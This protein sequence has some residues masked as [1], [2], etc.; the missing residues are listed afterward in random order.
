M[1][2]ECPGQIE[3]N[4]IVGLLFGHKLVE[5]LIRKHFIFTTKYLLS[6]RLYTLSHVLHTEN[7][8]EAISLKEKLLESEEEMPKSSL[9][10]HIKFSIHP[11]QNLLSLG[12]QKAAVATIYL[13]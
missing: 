7:T 3:N 11:A 13:M 2:R 8:I 5:Q 9:N 1:K 4:K 10:F 6:V 12:M